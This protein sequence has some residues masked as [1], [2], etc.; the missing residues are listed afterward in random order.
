MTVLE[1]Q[2]INKTYGR[3][4]VLNDVSITVEK[5]EIFGLIGPNGA[6]KTTLVECIAGLRQPDGGQIRVMGLD[7]HKDRAALRRILGIQLQASQLPDKIKVW[8]A[9]DWFSGF[10]E[11][12]EDWN[13]ILTALGLEDKRNDTFEKL[14]GGQ[15]QRLSV[16]LALVGRPEILI[17]DELTTGLDPE[18]R[19][20]IW[21][22][23]ADARAR[24]VTILLVSHFMEEAERLCDRLAVMDSG[25]VV[26]LDTPARIIANA[27]GEQRLR[28]R[29]SVPLEDDLLAAL[30]DVQRVIRSGDM[31]TV[32]GTGN[33]VQSVTAVLARNQIIAHEL[34]IE[35]TTLDDAFIALTA[36][37]A[38]NGSNG[39][40]V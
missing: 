25:Q 34:R 28:F 19:R 36:S 27:G 40:A 26:A 9:L 20:S 31:V 22:Y 24:G 5:G 1:V 35:Q 6:G 7:P 30:P 10:Y 29:P 32:A 14:S 21:Q 33:L 37:K 3:R 12:P 38:N 13:A 23:I 8:E 39:G 17:L 2:N 16:A 15:K 4:A 18:A 11:N